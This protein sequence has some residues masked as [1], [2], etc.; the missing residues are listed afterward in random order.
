MTFKYETAVATLV[1]FITLSLLG[2]ANGVNS[3]VTTCHGDKGDC[4]SNLIVSLIFFILTALWFGAVWVLGYAAQERRSKRLAQ[5]LI[6]AEV[7]IAMAALFNARHHTDVLSLIT[8]LVD[9]LLAVWIITLAFRL[10]RAGGGRV[11]SRQRGR[12]RRRPTTRQ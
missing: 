5:L 6:C 7:L 10:M 11:V 1:Q 8:S 2:I 4:V 12:A 3:V 9:L